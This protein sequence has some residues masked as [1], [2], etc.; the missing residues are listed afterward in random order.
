MRV[1]ITGAGRGFGRGVAEQLAAA[2]HD[3]GLVARTASDLF[4]VAQ[5]IRDAGRI[6]EV[7]SADVRDRAAVA[8]AFDHLAERLGGLDAVAHFAGGEGHMGPV[9]EVAWEQWCRPFFDDARGA[10]NVATIA[11]DR[12]VTRFVMCSSMAAVSM[13]PLVSAYCAGALGRLALAEALRKEVEDRGVVV[14]S[15][16]PVL[17]P[18]GG[19]GGRSIPVFAKY[20][21]VTPEEIIEAR[22]TSPQLTAAG[23]G[24][25]VRDLLDIAPG[26]AWKVDSSGKHALPLADIAA[27][28]HTVG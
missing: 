27:T 22:V 19:V 23:V 15:V 7:A 3:V 11:L 21:G 12:G 14:H 17:S 18:H 16:L 1:L 20:A 6:A 28:A 26:G 24:E 8:D 4:E 5:P 2:G 13:T 25:V 9:S 10:H